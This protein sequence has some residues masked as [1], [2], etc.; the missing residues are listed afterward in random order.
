MKIAQILIIAS[1]TMVLSPKH[2][3]VK[4][5]FVARL[6]LKLKKQKPCTLRYTKHF[7]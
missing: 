2:Q 5:Q 1:I 4:F 7:L 6:K 3:L